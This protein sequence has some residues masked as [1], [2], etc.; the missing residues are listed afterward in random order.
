MA[1]AVKASELLRRAAKL[2][3]SKKRWTRRAF[4][5]D[6]AGKPCNPT[7]RAARSF[8]ALGALEHVGY[9]Y[10]GWSAALDH[11]SC[12]AA[13]Q[14]GYVTTRQAAEAGYSTDCMH[15]YCCGA[16]QHSGGTSP[17]GS[18]TRR[19]RTQ[20]SSKSHFLAGHL[21]GR[22]PDGPYMPSDAG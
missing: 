5:R 6:A 21:I 22:R 12:T 17:G 16:S 9:N 4:A 3:A 8:C 13:G 11:L 2:I 18:G 7:S 14:S 19:Q 10:A 1:A 20:R 15:T